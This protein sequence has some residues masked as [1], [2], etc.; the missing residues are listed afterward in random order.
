MNEVYTVLIVTVERV[1]AKSLA[2][3]G[4]VL[5][6]QGEDL[7]DPDRHVSSLAL[8]F[9]SHS[10]LLGGRGQGTEVS[11]G[12]DNLFVS[13]LQTD[14]L[15]EVWSGGLLNTCGFDLWEKRKI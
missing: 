5:R 4:L 11:R 7:I 8:E 13:L 1:S 3:K 15:M 14:G 9:V 6:R 10:R 2:M 12:Q